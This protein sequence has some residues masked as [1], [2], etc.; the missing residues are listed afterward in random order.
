[1]PYT[2]VT[3][4]VQPLD[5]WRDILMVELS[6]IGYDTFEESTGGLNAYIASEKFDPAALAKLLTLRDPHVSVNWTSLEITD[7]NW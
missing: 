4:I 3:F 5:P 6:D 7:R 1:M 2:Q